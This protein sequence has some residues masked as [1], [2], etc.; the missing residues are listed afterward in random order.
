M[1]VQMLEKM[2]LKVLEDEVQSHVNSIIHR[3]VCPV[4]NLQ[5]V[6]QRFRDVLQ[7]IQHESIK[8]FYDYICQGDGLVVI[9]PCIGEFLGD[10]WRI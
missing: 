7:V 3:P 8:G 6:Q 9:Q 5:G 2:L 10:W 1:M 4:G